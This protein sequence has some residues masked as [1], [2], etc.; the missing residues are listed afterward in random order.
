[1]VLIWYYTKNLN[2][3]WCSRKLGISAVSVV[4]LPKHL[5]YCLLVICIFLLFP[6]AD[7]LGRVKEQFLTCGKLKRTVQGKHINYYFN[8]LL[9]YAVVPPLSLFLHISFVKLSKRRQNASQC[10][11]HFSVNISSKNKDI[12]L[13]NSDNVTPSK[14]KINE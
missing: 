14:I 6:V 4:V 11:K 7:I 3:W 10:F 13:Y 2:H 5:F 12:F 1:M 9:I 8:L